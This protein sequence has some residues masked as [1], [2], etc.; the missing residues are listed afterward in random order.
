MF[1]NDVSII[2]EMFTA[3][4][5]FVLRSHLKPFEISEED[6]IDKAIDEVTNDNDDN[7]L[8]TSSNLVDYAD[9][10]SGNDA[11]SNEDVVQ[12]YDEEHVDDNDVVHIDKSDNEN[13]DFKTEQ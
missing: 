2:C 11:N 12:Y 6:Q 10:E 5:G 8:S 1:C 9:E 13:M 4:Q 3:Q 7:S